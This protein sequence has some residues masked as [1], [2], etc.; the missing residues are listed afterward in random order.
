[1]KFK[2]LFLAFCC[3]AFGLTES[4]AQDQKNNKKGIEIFMADGQLPSHPIRIYERDKD[5]TNSNPRLCL[6]RRVKVV[7]TETDTLFCRDKD[8]YFPFEIAANQKWIDESSGHKVSKTG[9]LLLFDLVNFPISPYRS[10]ARVLPIVRWEEYT[11]TIEGDSAKVDTVLHSGVSAKEIYL[12][13]GPGTI[14]WTAIIIL[15]FFALA[16]WVTR[17]NNKSLLGLIIIKKHVSMSLTQMALWTIAVGAV[18]LGFGLMRL[19]VPN[20][21]DNLVLLM[22]FATGTSA[23]GHWQVNRG[24]RLKKKEDE[25][26][27]IKAA[28][29]GQKKKKQNAKD[30]EDANEPLTLA[31]KF[32]TL[33]MV[34]VGDGK[35]EPSIAKAQMLFWTLTTLSL[36]VVKSLLEGEL[37]DVPTQLVA[38]MGVSQAGFLS[39]KEMS[40]GE[41]SKNV[42]EL[43]EEIAK[44]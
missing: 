33:I 42:K 10:G 5:L 36:F 25:L 39:R 32:K 14:F 38:L 8:W 31:E 30:K 34:D 35:Y 4:V 9:S 27:E 40:V 13:N 26:K 3:L 23:A 28:K 44:K 22:G 24:R 6:T 20:I 16:F 41:Q 18:V 37:W 15:I 7:E 17:A 29:A 12:S 43:E 1:M 2:F 11:T 19:Q 21:P